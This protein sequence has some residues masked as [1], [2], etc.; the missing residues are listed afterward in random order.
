MQIKD[1]YKQITLSA[2]ETIQERNKNAKTYPYF[3]LRREIKDMVILGVQK[4]LDE[5]VESGEIKAN[6]TMKGIGYELIKK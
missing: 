3:A 1:Q 5:L 2:I 4:I 6:D